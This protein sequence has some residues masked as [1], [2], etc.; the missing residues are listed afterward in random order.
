MCVLS[1]WLSG[2]HRTPSL[3][4]LRAWVL[5]TVKLCLYSLIRGQGATQTSNI[6][7][8]IFMGALWPANAGTSVLQNSGGELLKKN[9]TRK[10]SHEAATGWVT[11]QNISVSPIF[12]FFWGGERLGCTECDLQCEI[13]LFW[14]CVL[15]CSGHTSVNAGFCTHRDRCILWCMWQ[16]NFLGQKF[17]L[18]RIW[19]VHKQPE[20]SQKCKK[21]KS[22]N[23]FWCEKNKV[24]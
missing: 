6:W 22:E 19:N 10:R 5:G 23:H 4:V 7:K 15:P 2:V 11:R 12:K 17:I 3:A 9:L 8:Q 20:N 18:T 21:C 14:A 13:S 1:Y 24:E 16:H